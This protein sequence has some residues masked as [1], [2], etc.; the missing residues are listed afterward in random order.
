M[1]IKKI[2]KVLILGSGGLSIGQGGEFDY[3]G[4]QAIKALKEENIYTILVNPN[5]A[6]IQTSWGFADRVY[7]LPVNAD[8]VMGVI[9]KERPDSIILGFG[10]QTALNCGVELYKRGVFSK[11][12]VEILGTP[13]E[14]II[15]TEDR[16]LFVKKLDEINVKVP[17]SIAVE[18]VASCDVA[19]IIQGVLFTAH[20]PFHP[21]IASYRMPE[22]YVIH[23]RALVIP[24]QRSSLRPPA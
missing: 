9:E 14:T 7:F 8:F 15:A 17:A 4:S 2:K 10:G 3:S 11:F 1:E 18:T 20:L 19:I 22:C 6:T 13:I 24:V 23:K 5:I 21:D 16:K 12:D